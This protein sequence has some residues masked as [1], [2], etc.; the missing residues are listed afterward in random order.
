MKN[1][2]GQNWKKV[3]LGL[4]FGAAVIG[5]VAVTAGVGL[6]AGGVAASAFGGAVGVLAG[7][8]AGALCMAKINSVARGY[9]F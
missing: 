1:N 9:A 2:N 5:A 8:G 3:G 4:I 7:V 6:V